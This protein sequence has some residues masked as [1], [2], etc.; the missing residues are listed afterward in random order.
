MELYHRKRRAS[1]A[2]N[3]S[4]ED[5]DFLC[6]EINRVSS[7]T[8]TL[9][10][11]AFYANLDPARIPPTP[12]GST[13][14]VTCAL[15]ALDGLYASLHIAPPSAFH[16]IWPR[17]WA[18]IK[19]FQ[20]GTEDREHSEE[21]EHQLCLGFVTF[22]ASLSQTPT[23]SR[24]IS[25]TAGVR[26]VI[27][28]AWWLHVRKEV[29]HE[30]DMSLDTI[31]GCIVGVVQASQSAGLAEYIRG[32]GGSIGD[33]ASLVIKTISQLVPSR[34]A[35]V[36]AQT[37]KLVRGLLQFII[38]TDHGHDRQHDA[39]SLSVA[40][41][42]RGLA[43]VLT[44]V[45]D[46][47]ATGTLA[48]ST[49]V[50]HDSF[51]LLGITFNAR[52]GYVWIGEA[53]KSG[54]LHAMVKS[55]NQGPGSTVHGH[56]TF[57]LQAI[58]PMSLMYYSVVRHME[59]ALADIESIV[60]GSSLARTEKWQHF[61]RLARERIII[62]K[63][64]DAPDA[65][66]P[67]ACDNL[68]C[69]VI[70]AKPSFKRCAGCKNAYYCSR[71]CQISDWRDGGHDRTCSPALNLPLTDY[72]GLARRDRA[73]IR[74][75]VQ[76]DYE[77]QRVENIYPSQ[78]ACM[79]MYPGQAFYTIF[80]YT[81]GRAKIEV[82]NAT[83][84]AEIRHFSGAEWATALSRAARSEGQMELHVVQILSA[85][86]PRY[87]L[88]PLRINTSSLYDGLKRISGVLP[89]DVGEAHWFMSVT[90]DIRVL[91]REKQQAGLQAIH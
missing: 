11:P 74:A 76:N 72:N 56:L 86:L 10:L 32:A 61:V 66:W 13:N 49:H 87:W 90:R 39:P 81:W 19:F 60:P 26:N 82:I 44:M 35:S 48:E 58:L 55:G 77:A 22:V 3:G 30:H 38:T 7:T 25:G 67:T 41:R 63:A 37:V 50:L 79:A 53:V 71:A 51:T 91:I 57:L 80:D 78:A 21:A 68:K 8:G 40:L 6:R 59:G 62:L 14:A 84:A 17:Y 33:L 64:L 85:A 4:A 28:R 69:G 52:Q 31:I 34:S 16:D 88:L 29:S 70:S 73:F 45:I 5:L 2:A 9:F 42:N 27:A 15:A 65:V 18:W 23:L 47:V 36:S 43:R 20:A 89:L 24:L 12:E 75:V 83:H 46:T 54:L 1:A